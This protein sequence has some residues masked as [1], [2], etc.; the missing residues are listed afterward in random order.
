MKF[1]KLGFFEDNFEN[2]RADKDKK[3]YGSDR[4]EK[5]PVNVDSENVKPNTDKAENAQKNIDE[6][7][8][9]IEENHEENQVRF[10]IKSRR[11]PSTESSSK[12]F[13]IRNREHLTD[14]AREVYGLAIDT[15]K[16]L[17]DSLYSPYFE[18]QYQIEY[19]VSKIYNEI[20]EN[21]F[22]EGFS[23]FITPSNYLYSHNV[24]TAMI[25]MSCAISLDYSPETVL[26]IGSASFLH[27]IGIVEFI[28]II[29]NE[30]RLSSQEIAIVK[31]HS[32][33][34]V[35]IL[36]R[37]TDLDYENK[38]IF[39]KMIMEVHERYDGS[40]Y[41]RGIRGDELD[42]SASLIAI[43]DTYEALSHKRNW[44]EAYEPTVVMRFFL[45]EFK[46]Q[47]HP[48]ALKALILSKGMYPSG[49]IVRLSS[50]DIGI[51]VLSNKKNV[52]RPVVEV[53]L[54]ASFSPIK[55]YYLDLTEHPLMAI[56]DEELYSEVARR[57]PDFYSNF[58]M[59]NFW[60][61]WG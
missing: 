60:L 55:P 25:S 34:G 35:Q 7:S 57:N 51:V 39:S 30:R 44:R 22:F 1:S 49:S 20:K 8:E 11:T 43:A 47:F 42:E 15:S 16:R 52:T 9:L 24:N 56:E 33:R 2:S 5:S 48:Q 26:K 37:I 31:Q 10:S 53:V 41:P 40:G 46:S 13:V 36:D 4:I 54:D 28:D 59:K 29:K 12:E 18:A 23:N 27:D 17:M 45:N 38:K 6:S 21:P 61:D 58:E 19:A 32:E 14:R 50:G 3:S